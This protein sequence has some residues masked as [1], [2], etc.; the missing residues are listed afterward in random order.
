MIFFQDRS[1]DLTTAGAQQPKWGGGGSFGLNGIMY[2]HYCNS[3]D[4]AHLGTNCNA[5]AYKDQLSLQGGSC[6]NTFVIGNI[7]T[8]KLHLGGTPC[9]EMDLNPNALYYVLKAALLQ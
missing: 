6:S 2:F 1:A 3:A 8:D 9:V 4:G 7:I 5:S